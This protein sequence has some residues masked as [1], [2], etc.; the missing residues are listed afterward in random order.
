MK[1]EIISLLTE[2]ASLVLS[3]VNL[4]I[5]CSLA[6]QLMSMV[7]TGRDT[8]V[9]NTGVSFGD[10]RGGQ[11]DRWPYQ[12]AVVLFFLFAGIF[13]VVGWSR[14]AG[15][16]RI[17]G[18]AILAVF[19]ISRIVPPGSILDNHRLAGAVWAVVLGGTLVLVLPG[20]PSYIFELVLVSAAVF[21]VVRT[22][23]TR[24]IR[25]LVILWGI[26]AGTGLMLPGL[27]RVIATTV[28]PGMLAL[29]LSVVGIR[30]LR[31][32]IQE[33]EQI[34]QRLEY[35]AYHDQLTGLGNRKS[36]YRRLQ[37]SVL[38]T[39]EP[40]WNEA[41]DWRAVLIIDIDHFKHVNDS[42]GN[43]VGNILLIRTS[44]HISGV[45]PDPNLVFRTG[46]DEFGIILEGMASELDAAMVAEKIL[47][48]LA[49][50]FVHEDHRIYVSLSIGITIFPRDG[51]RVEV[52]TANADHALQEAK[53]DRNTYRF[54]TPSMQERA[55]SRIQFINYLRQAIDRKEMYLAY[56]PQVCLEGRVTGAEVLLRWHHPVLGQVSPA[57]FI[58]IAEETGLIL[59]I[60]SWVIEQACKQLAL[61]HKEGFHI[62]LA[63]NLS[64]KQVKDVKLQRT[65]IAHLRQYKLRPEFLHLEITENSLLENAESLISKIQN[66]ADL[67]FTFSIDDFGTGY[68]SLSYLKRLPIATVKIDRSFI[69]ELPDNNQDAALVEAIISMVHGLGLSVV[70]EGVDTREQFEFL[71]DRGC[72]TL[73]GYL[74]SVPLEFKEFLHYLRKPPKLPV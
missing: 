73:Q 28:V 38:Q 15:F 65:I 2:H 17:A 56:Q 42:A 52:I 34:E 74:F 26:A 6:V 14:A 62:P 72:G 49:E 66:L 39:V 9:E 25:F 55:V 7:L 22:S 64:P 40:H 5:L 70:A 41:S 13:E 60:G 32:R 67:G 59:A 21:G 20:E 44:Q 53:I 37:S 57:E 45:V 27:G 36:F 11:D 35:L 24:G 68:S 58:P 50:P 33:A 61:L 71:R 4:G 54:Y 19:R 18:Y 48:T 69:T 12:F 1:S 47:G 43:E 29:M 30:H 51:N 46:G 3:L 16:G 31:N 63:V 8:L 10:P 23:T